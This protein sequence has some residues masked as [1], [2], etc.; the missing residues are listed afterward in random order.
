MNL[1]RQTRS[2]RHEGLREIWCGRPGV[3]FNLFHFTFPL[4]HTPG[5][6]HTHTHFSF[7][8]LPLLFPFVFWKSDYSSQCPGFSARNPLPTHGA[9]S[10]SSPSLGHF[11]SWAE[12]E[13]V[14]LPRWKMSCN[15]STSMI[16][17]C[18]KPGPFQDL[19]GAVWVV[20]LRDHFEEKN[21]A[22]PDWV[23]HEVW[24]DEPVT[25]LYQ[26]KAVCSPLYWEERAKVGQPG[27]NRWVHHIHQE[28]VLEETS[29]GNIFLVYVIR[30]SKS[31]FL[32][33]NNSLVC[34]IS[35]WSLP[36]FP[37][38]KKIHRHVNHIC[39]LIQWYF[40]SETR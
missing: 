40:L 32:G 17:R 4:I 6:T 11:K 23:F 30:A 27:C 28:I 19:C 18:S 7:L 34:L 15:G 31:S 26:P 20:D 16:L 22:Y 39:K 13:D 1:R 24:P 36:W 8:L 5:D 38:L 10:A 9:K 29:W 25:L 37:L 2:L 33:K 35:E 12:L 21:L 3:V 14:C